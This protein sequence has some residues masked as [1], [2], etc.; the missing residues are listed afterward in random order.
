[1]LTLCPKSNV[2]C[3]GAPEP[4]RSSFEKIPFVRL[5][6]CMAIAFAVQIATISGVNAQSYPARPIRLVV[7]FAP[8][9]ANDIVAR[10]LAQKL[11][12]V[13]GQQIVVDNRAGADGRIAT[14]LVAKSQVDGYTIL[15]VPTSFSYG[16]AGL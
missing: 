11:A 8:G 13:L 1:M 9:G 6:Y 7:G 12:E 16:T 5:L 15:L 4:E 2:K 3:L 10:I 14:E